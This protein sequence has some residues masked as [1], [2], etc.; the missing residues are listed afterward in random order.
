M[1]INLGFGVNLAELAVSELESSWKLKKL[2]L[3][4]FK[5]EYTGTVLEV[6]RRVQCTVQREEIYSAII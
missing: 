2:R 5:G 3:P 6:F 1:S 4:R